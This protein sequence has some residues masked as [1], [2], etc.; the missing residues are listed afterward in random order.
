MCCNPALFKFLFM[1]CYLLHCEQNTD[2]YLCTVKT[3]PLWDAY[4]CPFEVFIYCFSKSCSCSVASTWIGN[5]CMYF[6]NQKDRLS[7]TH[8]ICRLL[9]VSK[10]YCEH[11]VLTDSVPWHELCSLKQYHLI[12]KGY[13]SSLEC[14]PN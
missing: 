11:T 9:G 10:S 13:F 8:C 5:L 2:T 7:K 4:C 14:P 3:A 1:L 12:G 6:D